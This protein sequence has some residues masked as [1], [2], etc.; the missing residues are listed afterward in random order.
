MVGRHHD[1]HDLS[2]GLD[3]LLSGVRRI[4]NTSLLANHFIKR[5]VSRHRTG[6]KPTPVIGKAAQSADPSEFAR[7]R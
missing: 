4:L 2:N 5:V 6:A 3:L 1:V 7:T